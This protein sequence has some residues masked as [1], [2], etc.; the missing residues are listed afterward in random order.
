LLDFLRKCDEIPKACRDMLQAAVPL[1]LEV[2][3][4][5]RHKFQVEVLDRV[6]SLIA[7]LEGKKRAGISA[8]EEELAAIEADRAQAAA[9]ANV[10]KAL[11]TEK[12]NQ[13][14]EKEKGV[15]GVREIANGAKKVLT[16]AQQAQ[17]AFNAKKAGLLTEQET[18]AKLLADVFLPLKEGTLKGNPAKQKKLVGDLKH[19]LKEL[20]AQTALGDALAAT[21]KM[22]PAKRAGTFAKTTIEFTEEYFTKHTAKVAQDIAGLD[23]QAASHD[24]AIAA[25]QAVLGEKK[26]AS[27]VVEKEWDAMQD[28]WV[29]LDKDAAEAARTL[30]QIEA[31]L[32]KLNKSIDKAKLDLEKFLEV[33]SL[34]ATLKEKSTAV[35]AVTHLSEPEE[36]EAEEEEAA[37]EGEQPDEAMQE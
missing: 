22:T 7:S 18:F 34:F 12:E 14:A 36:V 19:K 4:A 28:V 2:V 10:K 5:D 35:P 6:A 26:A 29:S 8:F 11:S 15:D 17:E 1:C 32:P 25:A 33:P 30:K 20:G 21:L 37:G 9:T 27:D 24:T 3:E 23:A 16:E 13:C 31:Q